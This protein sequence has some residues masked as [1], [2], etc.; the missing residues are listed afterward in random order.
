MS[1][2]CGMQRFVRSVYIILLGCPTGNQHFSMESLKPNDKHCRQK[3]M[4]YKTNFL[5][6]VHRKWELAHNTGKSSAIQ[7]HIS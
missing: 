4:K 1:S 2:Y 5:C 7:Q 3:E 6:E